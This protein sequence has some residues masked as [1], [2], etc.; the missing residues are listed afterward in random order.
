MNQA[1]I[2]SC[3]VMPNMRTFIKKKNESRLLKR[4]KLI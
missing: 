3:I 1:E 2:S 4:I